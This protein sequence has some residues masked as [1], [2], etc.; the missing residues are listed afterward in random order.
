M[1]LFKKKSFSFSRAWQKIGFVQ[2]FH[3]LHTGCTPYLCCKIQRGSRSA[4]KSNVLAAL[5]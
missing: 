5:F 1:I 3:A 2:V 4:E